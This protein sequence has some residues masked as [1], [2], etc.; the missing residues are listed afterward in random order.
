[1]IKKK[2]KIL[3]IIPARLGSK[4][5]KKKNLKKIGKLSLVEHSVRIAKNSKFI[6][7]IAVS[8]D[9]QSIQKIAKKNKVWCDKLRPKKYSTK[10]SSTYNAI[11]FI[12][13]HID[14]KPD[15]IIELH[16]TYVFR[17]S[18]TID[19]AIR[20]ILNSQNSDSLISIKKIDDTSHPDFVINLPNKFISYKKSPIK[21]NRHFLKPKYM[22][23]GFIIVSKINSFNKAKSMIGKNCIG[24]E[25]SNNKEII[26]INNQLD[27]TFASFL[28]NNNINYE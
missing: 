19:R 8:T 24:F 25:M 23:L 18:S 12:I 26:D 17:K 15:L 2:Y 28:Y 11:K 21:F 9:S 20:I 22:S 13:D 5:L 16:P 14:Y 4:G 3:A 27:F 1:M 10:K 6:S 7:R